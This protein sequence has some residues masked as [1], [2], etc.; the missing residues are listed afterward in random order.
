MPTLK[1]T[2]QAISFSTTQAD[3]IGSRS[4]IS[5]ASEK[6][7]PMTKNVSVK[8]ESRKGMAV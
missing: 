5:A 3:V 4:R 2:N 6:I 1:N 8:F 7:R